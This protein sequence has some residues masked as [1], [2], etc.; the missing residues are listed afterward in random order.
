MINMTRAALTASGLVQTRNAPVHAG[1]GYY[2]GGSSSPSFVL[3]LAV[4][5]DSVAYCDAGRLEARREQRWVFAD[6]VSRAGE[7]V[8]NAAQQAAMGAKGADPSK[9]MGRL[10][11]LRAKVC[12][13][14]VED[15]GAPVVFADHDRVRFVVTSDGDAYSADRYGVLVNFD[16]DKNVATIESARSVGETLIAAGFRVLSATVIKACPTGA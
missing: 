6:L 9:A 12:A 7:T 5:E 3:V 8:R 14:R 15:H 4:T 11:I 2:M 13:D 16:S 10:A 1:H